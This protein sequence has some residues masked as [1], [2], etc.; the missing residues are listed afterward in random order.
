MAFIC[1]T[2]LVLPNS[3]NSRYLLVELNGSPDIYVDAN[4]R[5]MNP[6]Y[7]NMDPGMDVTTE[8]P[9][10]LE[11]EEEPTDDLEPRT[12]PADDEGGT[13]PEIEY[14]P[15]RK[16]NLKANASAAQQG[17]YRSSN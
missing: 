11:P 7:R 6:G 13:L 3:S 8:G 9:E 16:R 1:F 17:G 15:A 4:Y 10:M 12:L 5:N 14:Q 2:L